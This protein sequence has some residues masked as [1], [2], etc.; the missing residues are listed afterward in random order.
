MTKIFLLFL[1][2]FLLFFLSKQSDFDDYVV[3]EDDA[4]FVVGMIIN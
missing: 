1:F 2:K 3:E 4:S